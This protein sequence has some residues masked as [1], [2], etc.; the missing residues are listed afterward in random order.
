MKVDE[1][2]DIYSYGVVLMELLTGKKPLEPEYGESV[3]IVEWI[4][5]KM[6]KKESLEEALDVNVGSN[7][8]VREE[9]LLVLR[10]AIL[11]TAKLPKERPSMRDVLTMLGEAK[12][13]RKSG[14][15]A[16]AV[17]VAV[18]SKDNPVFSS[19]PVNGLL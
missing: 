16:A 14:G 12:P 11:C 18:A 10:L 3:D 5:G 2:S 19:S 8:H 6:R 13:R 4:R 7:K 9:M 17:A 1:K 15:N